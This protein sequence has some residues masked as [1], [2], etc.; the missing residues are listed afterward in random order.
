MA[1]LNDYAVQGKLQNKH[2]LGL[3][4]SVRESLDTINKLILAY[5]PPLD[6]RGAA[7]RD[8]RTLF[9]TA[10]SSASPAVEIGKF[11]PFKL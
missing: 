6:S 9:E 10:L 5:R 1:K 4:T 7:C 2:A 8:K 11:L 3:I